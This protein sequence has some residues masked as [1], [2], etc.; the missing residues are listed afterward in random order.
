MRSDRVKRG[1]ERAPARALM[2]ATGFPRSAMD[3]PLIGISSSYTDIIPGHMGMRDLERYAENGIHANGGYPF[4]FSVPGVC[5]GIAMGHLGMHYSLPS[6]ELIADMIE[7][8]TEAHAFDG[9]LMITNCD[10][11]S[12]GMVMAAGR[13]D[14]PT[15]VVTAGPM[16]SGRYRGRRLSLIRDT[17]EAVGLYQKGDI[18]DEELMCLEMEACPGEG[19][20]QGMYT[21]NTVACLIE[22]LGLSL[23][24][25]GTGLAGSGKKR[26]IAFESGFR[27]VDLIR[28]NATSRK[29]LT[30]ESFENAITADL[31]LGG[32]TNTVLHLPAMAYEAGV[33]LG[34]DAFDRISRTTPHLASMRP[35]GVHFMEDLDW[36][37]GISGL[38]KRLKDK[39]HDTPTVSGAS[40]LEIASKAEIV[41]EEVIRPVEKAHSPEGGLAILTGNLAPNG[42]VVKRAAVD[43]EMMVY[44]GEAVVFES[45]ED[46]MKAIMGGK[47]KAGHVVVIRYE[48]PKGGPGMREMLSPTSA[49]AGMGLHKSVALVT[50]GRFSGGTRGPC[51]GHVSPEAM[52]GGPIGL[53]R[54][55]DKIAI[56]IPGRSIQ[57]LV[58]DAELE[59]RRA[60]WKPLP[61][62]ITKGWLGRYAQHVTSANTGAVLKRSE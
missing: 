29:F 49:I 30:K 45:E 16:L 10:K 54:N 56:D 32:S 26:R 15:V 21:A 62:K 59:K 42:S 57:L 33:D 5:D 31:A 55:G 47:V 6:R 25:C 20:C 50:D 4:I 61:P 36:A 44:T 18:S 51:I 12:P 9:L 39:L 43:P 24:G 40:T 27:L 58:D 60:E 1:V 38:L 7:S 8:V 52:E 11:I 46:A 37:G 34:V 2:H 3:R 23:P 28:E 14:I 48:G 22:V 41:D 53:V 35:G 13:L 19:S 17:F